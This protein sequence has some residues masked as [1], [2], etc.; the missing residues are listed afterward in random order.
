MF[1]VDCIGVDA[2]IKMIQQT[3]LKKF[4]IYRQN[5]AKGSTPIY[6]FTEG[7]QNAVSQKAFKDWAMNM[8]ANSGNIYEILLFNKEGAENESET[9]RKQDKIRFTFALSGSYMNGNQ[10]QTQTVDVAAAVQQALNDYDQKKKIEALEAKIKELEEEEEEEE[11]EETDIVE[12]ISGIM[13]LMNDQKAKA[14]INGDEIAEP[15]K[16][17]MTKQN[18]FDQNSNRTERLKA[19]LQE[20]KQHNE[21]YIE[22]L[23]R[24]AKLA[25]NNPKLFKSILS[26]LRLVVTLP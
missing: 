13:A 16:E 5:A 15:K 17:T 25:K 19:A 14:V 26:K 1:Q 12:K 23:E 22:D 24:L 10:Q 20:I 7:N 4:I 8:N 21:N 9:L 6:E 11:E 2:V 3:G 18:N